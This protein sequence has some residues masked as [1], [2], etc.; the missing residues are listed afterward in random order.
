M[1][2]GRYVRANRSR[3]GAVLVA[4]VAI[5]ALATWLEVPLDSLITVGYLERSLS[6]ATPIALAA[7]GGLYAERSGVFNIG[8]E[9][10]MIFGAVNAVGVAWL[11]AGDGPVT[12][13]HL[14][15]GIVGSVLICVVYT[16][17]FAV[18][19]IRYKANQIVAGLAVWILGLGFGPLTAV[20]L[21]GSQS[22]PRVGRISQLTIPGLAEIPVLGDVLFDASPVVMLTLVLVGLAWLFMYR[23]QYGYWI[24]AAGEN[25]EALDTAGVSVNRIR[26]AAVI[27]S[28][29]MAGLGGAILAVGLSSGFTGGGLTMVDGRGWIGI[30]AYLFGNYNPI[31]AFLAAL[32][33]GAANM[34]Q[35][36]LQ[37]ANIEVSATLTGL[38]PYVVVIV[39]LTLYG[40]T[41]MP[42]RVGEPYE[43]ES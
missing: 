16:S 19:L 1:S 43:S 18:L 15:L 8:L 20:L 25:P 24:Q 2:A 9:G 26:Y 14:W 41:R 34:F 37:T 42:S 3:I 31:G 30:V 5:W 7:V 38:L 40:R 28:G 23:T 22:S 17:I 33:F 12:E 11:L 29:A 32:L 39:V 21:W 35:V 6:A 4:I 10:F 27:F 13:T 36:Q